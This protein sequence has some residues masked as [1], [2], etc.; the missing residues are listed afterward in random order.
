VVDLT[1]AANAAAAANG[2][3]RAAA[4]QVNI[5]TLAVGKLIGGYLAQWCE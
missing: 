3:G 1:A 5:F 4:Q 2:A